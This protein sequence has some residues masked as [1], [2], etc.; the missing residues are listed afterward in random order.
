[1]E[2]TDESA[3]GITY[4]GIMPTTNRDKVLAITC[5]T[6]PT[7]TVETNPNQEGFVLLF[8]VCSRRSCPCLLAFG[9]FI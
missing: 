6:I 4:L 3:F 5:V 9:F 8:V 1:M 2:N 7:I